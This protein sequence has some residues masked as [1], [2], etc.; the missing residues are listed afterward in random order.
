MSYDASKF[1]STYDL[2]NIAKVSMP[3]AV[4]RFKR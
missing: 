4:D 1:E 3:N 2:R